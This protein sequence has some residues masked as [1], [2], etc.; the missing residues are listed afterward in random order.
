MKRLHQAIQAIRPISAVGQPKIVGPAANFQFDPFIQTMN[1]PPA[2][3][4]N[5]VPHPG[6]RP[7]QFPL[8][9]IE[10]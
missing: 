3:I 4:S 6:G 1:K 8:P 10:L 5:V 9:S 2:S 7:R